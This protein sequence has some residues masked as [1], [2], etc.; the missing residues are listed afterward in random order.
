M[1]TG[2]NFDELLNK[3]PE[4]TAFSL[5][6]YKLVL[7]F[8]A[9][10]LSAFAFAPTFLV[11]F[12]PISFPVLLY[13]VDMAVNYK[14]AALYG[15]IFGFG[16]FLGG[17]YWIS[18]ALFVFWD[19]FWF[20]FPFALLLLP[21]VMALY[22]SLVAVCWKFTRFTGTPSILAFIVI[23]LAS[24]ILRSYLFTGFPWN[25]MGHCLCF[26]TELLQISYRSG[27]YGLSI[28]ALLFSCCL[29]PLR[30][31]L[32]L[33]NLRFLG[34][35]VIIIFASYLYGYSRLQDNPSQFTDVNLRLIQPSISQT[36]K[37]R[38][39]QFSENLDRHIEL[40]KMKGLEGIDAVIW[41]EAALSANYNKSIAKLL[42]PAVP[43]DGLLITGSISHNY[44]K[45]SSSE[46]KNLDDNLK[47]YG[48]ILALDSTGEKQ[49][50]YKKHHLV[51]FGEFV[52]FK[53][54]LPIKKIT[55]GLVNQTPGELGVKFE[56]HKNIPPFRPL[57]CYESIFSYETR[58]GTTKCDWLLNIT[59]DAWYGDSP[60]PYQ[61]FQISR[62]RAIENGMPL[63][64][65][66]NNGITA[67][68]D[69]LGRIIQRTQLNQITSLDV[70]L[71]KKLID[72]NK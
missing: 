26:S 49:F 48:T 39:N 6:R 3:I 37:W 50:E 54:F 11:I 46:R 27:V 57:I 1:S 20:L 19:Q 63:V 34:G 7:L 15:W 12:L 10:L 42:T 31:G 35:V 21:A 60:G 18:F 72:H 32:K 44:E 23:W 33:E 25:L 55:P 59:N 22:I 66:G 43:K 2:K 58:H 71:P 41:P 53:N 13:S 29:Y 47:F 5:S 14:R 56:G 68:I 9:G 61:H 67:V 45:L 17:L 4:I 62:I 69:P 65:V 30:Y 64:R 36:E 52:P 51:P 28:L 70:R 8:T 38:D 16:Y 24:E 40:S